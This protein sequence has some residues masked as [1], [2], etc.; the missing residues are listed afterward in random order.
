MARKKHTEDETPPVVKKKRRVAN[1]KAKG[2]QFQRV[3]ADILSKASGES[4]KSVPAS[5]SLRWSNNDHFVFGDIVPPFGYNVVT[6]CKN[7][8]VIGI[9]QLVFKDTHTRA[10]TKLFLSFWQ[11]AVTDAHRATA[12]LGATFVP[13][14]VF[15]R[16]HGRPVCVLELSLFNRAWESAGCPEITPFM[17]LEIK[18]WKLAMVD[19]E[20][21]FGNVH[22]KY[23]VAEAA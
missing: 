15:K 7:H 5:G 9:D 23:F 16:S 22:P 6:E 1:P 10:D 17:S 2:S 20:L 8:R 21:L 4:W 3:V 11:Q 18:N 12:A 13:L 19:A 14:L